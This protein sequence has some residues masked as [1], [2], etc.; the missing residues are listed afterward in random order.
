MNL[1]RLQQDVGQAKGIVQDASREI[2]RSI[3]VVKSALGA[4]GITLSVG[5]FS[6]WIE[7]S[8]AAQAS[9]LRFAQTAGTTVEVFSS[10]RPAMKNSQTDAEAVAAGMQKLAKNMAESGDGTTKAA[11]VFDALK[12]SL[13]D[14]GGGMRQT[15][16]VMRELGSKLMSMKDQTLAVAF[17][18]ETF[19]KAGA[20]LLPFLYELARVGTQQAK[21]TR[22]QAEAAKHFE[23]N[24]IA[25]K[26]ASEQARNAFANDLL[27][28]LTKITDQM[29]AARLAAGDLTGALRLFFSA[30]RGQVADP[31]SALTATETQIAKL[32][33]QYPGLSEKDIG[34]APWFSFGR[35]DKVERDAA[36]KKL[37]QL[38][39]DRK[40]FQGLAQKQADSLGR[41]PNSPF[42]DF[43]GGG[44]PTEPKNPLGQN[45]ALLKR[46]ASTLQSLNKQYFDLTH[47]GTASFV[48]Y[49]TEHGTLLKLDTARKAELMTI[50]QQIDA[51]RR[52]TEIREANH[53]ARQ[54]E[55][56]LT[57]ANQEAITRETYEYAQ[58]REDLAFQITLMGKSGS[59]RRS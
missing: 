55:L 21:V 54:A 24:L 23:D 3:G 57:T 29:V 53:A 16:D 17:A 2:E 20:N 9:L 46:Y 38:E 1:A 11:K 14:A 35:T 22:E 47:A 45:E 52:L 6:K 28:T 7:G 49:E 36:A 34:D 13:T 27:P 40:Y 4:L 19:G 58:E 39:T 15:Q 25:L 26:G 37:Q 32:R 44:I 56:A 42:F 48:M 18:Q 30:T 50:A 59:S 10:L 12:I 41:D 33:E 43:S 8:F 51:Y 5:F 31:M